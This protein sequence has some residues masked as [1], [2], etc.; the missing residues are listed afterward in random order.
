MTYDDKTRFGD[1]VCIQDHDN[2]YGIAY[3]QGAITIG[4]VVH[5]DCP[6]AGHGPGVTTLLTC[7]KPLIEPVLDP[8]ASIADL[9]KIGRKY[10]GK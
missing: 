7:P 1:F 3:K 9:L 10:R 4:I 8:K 6:L 5:S 2:S